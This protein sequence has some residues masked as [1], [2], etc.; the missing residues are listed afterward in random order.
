MVETWP[1]DR[2]IGGAGELGVELSEAATL[3]FR[4]YGDLI[5][6]WSRR[7]NLTTIREPSAIVDR[8]FLD[9]LTCAVPA[10]GVLQGG[11]PISCI[12]VGAGV[13][14]PGI[15]LALAFPNVRLTLL[16][17]TR[18]RAEFLE[19]AVEHLA[20]DGARAVWARA[21]DAARLSEHRERY[22]LVVARALAPLPVALELCVPFAAIGGMVVLPRG[23]ESIAT[24]DVA[25]RVA[26]RLGGE[27]RDPMP[28][29][30]GFSGADRY[31]AV[32]D[33]AHPTPAAYPRRAGVPSR[34]PL[35]G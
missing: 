3:R 34:Q 11:E 18:K 21:E 25:G 2:L 5:V 12:D 32:V 20:L 22:R 28:L 1:L 14:L 24:L 8:H 17:S 27:A 4:D 35:T 31:L 23:A 29:T 26:T 30:Y 10:L 7:F 9:S 6:E 33:K 16:E 19:R 13:G 15:A